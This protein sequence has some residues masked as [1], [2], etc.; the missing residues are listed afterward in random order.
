MT[1]TTLVTLACLAVPMSVASVGLATPGGEG[2]RYTVTDLGPIHPGGSRAEAMNDR[3]ECV[4]S[5]AGPGAEGTPMLWLPEPAYGLPAGG[6]DLGNLGVPGGAAYGVNN[7]GRVVGFVPPVSGGGWATAY[8]WDPVTGMTELGS[9]GGTH[10]IAR[11][12]NDDGW[13]VG[14]SDPGGSTTFRAAF[15]WDGTTMVDLG[16][17]DDGAFQSRAYDINDHGQVAGLSMY[18][19]DIP[20]ASRLRAFLWLPEPAYGLPAG[21]TDIDDLSADPRQF[22]SAHGLNDRGQ[23]IIWGSNWLW[24]NGQTYAGFWLWLPEADFGLPAGMNNLRGPWGIDA[25][26]FGHD[27]NNRGEAV[28]RANIDPES[29]L[30]D[31]RAMLWRQGE[32]FDLYERIP[33]EDQLEWWFGSATDINDRGEI[34]GWGWRNGEARGFKLTPILDGPTECDA[35]VNGDGVVDTIDLQSVLVAWGDPGGPA[36]V[37]DDGIVDLQDL[38]AVLAGW[39]PCVAEGACCFPV[40]GDCELLTEPDCSFMGGVWNRGD[41]ATVECP[42]PA[43]GGCCFYPSSE[44]AELTAFD[45]HVAGGTWHGAASDCGTVACPEAPV[46]DWIGDPIVVDAL[47]YATTGNTNLFNGWTDE[48][49]DGWANAPEVVYAYTPKTDEI[50]DLSLCRDSRFD[51][52]LYVW[53]NDEDTVYACNDDTCETPSFPFP[54]ASRIDSLAL[55]AGNTYYIVVDGGARGP[56][57]GMYTLDIASVSP[58]ACCLPTEECGDLSIDVCE[59]SGGVWVDGETCATYACPPWP[60]GACCLP[61]GACVANQTE[62]DCVEVLGGM[63]MGEGT[64]CFFTDCP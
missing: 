34:C 52:K 24:P 30:G 2:T 22:T 36:D 6:H 37:N 11:A 9:L 35:D 40:T 45:C 7:H 27:I 19:D 43:T 25:T 21:M 33:F 48:H 26:A 5:G 46:G 58:A 42:A 20:D 61:D 49:C 51:T 44:C 57:S 23:T 8:V 10:G 60:R 3:G 39:G 41:C 50:V 4:G 18:L 1:S 47:P 28:F 56:V 62:Y 55:T 31:W 38:L 54:Y 32:W 59:A 13:V 64:I 12:I 16:A 29:L 53:E 63:W 14:E 17:F 15:L